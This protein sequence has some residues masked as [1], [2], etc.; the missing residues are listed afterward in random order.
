MFIG[1]KENKKREIPLDRHGWCAFV[2]FG[3]LLLFV[4]ERADVGG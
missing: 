3:V 1:N 2:A 4:G